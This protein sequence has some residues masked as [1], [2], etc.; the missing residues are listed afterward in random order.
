[1]EGFIASLHDGGWLVYAWL[2]LAA[3]FA[4]YVDSIAG[5]GGLITVPALLAAGL[6]PQVA[7]ATNKLQSTFGSGI[8]TWRYR[9]AGL[10]DRRPLGLAVA[11]TA[12]GAAAGVL[13]VQA[14]PDAW[15][16]RLIPLLLLLVLVYFL[17]DR[18]PGETDR[19]PRLRPAAFELPA[20]I[21]IGFY[22]GFLGPGTGSFWTAGYAFF[23]GHRIK[24]AAAHAKLMNFTSNAVAL[25]V[26]ML[27]GE[28]AWSM[29]LVMAGAQFAGASL[30]A[31]TLVRCQPGYVRL[32]LCVVVALTLLKVLWI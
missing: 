4:G 16:H 2:A 12:L 7:L 3:L 17:L 30:G 10:L 22:D 8:A 19:R 23:L 20:G 6:P 13:L 26:F 27:V 24:R 5:G 11:A 9:R 31:S 32:L 15:L 14:L 1:M 29:G 18:G 25:A 21:G 28:V